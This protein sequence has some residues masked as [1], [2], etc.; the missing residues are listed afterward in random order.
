MSRSSPPCPS[1]PRPWF[2]HGRARPRAPRRTF[3]SSSSITTSGPIRPAS[4]VSSA[5][6]HASRTAPPRSSSWTTTPSPI[7]RRGGCGAR[8]ACRCGGGAETTVSPAPST[9][10]AGSARAT[11]CC[12]STPNNPRT[13]FPRRRPGRDRAPR[14]RN[15]VLAS[16]AS[17]CAI[18]TAARSLG[19]AISDPGG[20][21]ARVCCCRAAPQ[22]PRRAATPPARGLGHRLLS[23]HPPRLLGATRRTRPRL[24][25]LLRGRGLCRRAARR[26]DRGLR[27]APGRDPP[28]TAS[29]PRRA[30]AHAPHHPPR[31]ADLCPQ[32]LAEPGRRVSWPAWSRVEAWRAALARLKGDAGDA[33]K[34]STTSAASPPTSAAAGPRRGV[35][36]AA[37]RGLAPG[38]TPCRL[39]VGGH[40]QS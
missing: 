10:A 37:A 2:L 28:S 13:G 22:V 34:C 5:R 33:R 1:S 38:G 18:P 14:A 15:R 21:A 27:T 7:R 36:A 31:P 26:L 6:R 16:S 32:A 3:R 17:A 23:A 9:R 29:R 19:R 35:A 12:C 11:G 4:S 20:H 39:A 40:P 24:L 25:P 8:P 30:A